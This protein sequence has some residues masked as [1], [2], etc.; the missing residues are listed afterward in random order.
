LIRKAVEEPEDDNAHT[1]VST[2]NTFVQECANFRLEKERFIAGK[3]H[4]AASNGKYVDM[5][6]GRYAY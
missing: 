2:L 1:F 5:D 3:I 6:I 4:H